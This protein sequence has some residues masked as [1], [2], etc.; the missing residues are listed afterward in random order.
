MIAD[1]I[2]FSLATEIVWLSAVSMVVA[3]EN[4]DRSRQGVC[5]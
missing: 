1:L 3:T 4:K 2:V 5:C